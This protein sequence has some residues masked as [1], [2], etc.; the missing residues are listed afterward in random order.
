MFV[1]A[2]LPFHCVSVQIRHYQRGRRALRVGLRVVR[3][4]FGLLLSTA[5]WFKPLDRFNVALTDCRQGVKKLSRIKRVALPVVP[6]RFRDVFMSRLFGR[7][8]AWLVAGCFVGQVG[9]PGLLTQQRVSVL[10]W[11]GGFWTVCWGGVGG[12]SQ[13]T[14]LGLWDREEVRLW[15]SPARGQKGDK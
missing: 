15:Q 2:L 9:Y 5:G 12:V 14:D 4:A 8:R 1:F 7:P 11:Q 10:L 13:W 6:L 3:C